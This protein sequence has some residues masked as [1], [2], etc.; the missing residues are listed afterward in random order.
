MKKY[1]PIFFISIMFTACFNSSSLE[2]D[3]EICVKENKF[4]YVTEVLDYRT[5]QMKP[6][7]ICK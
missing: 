2:D 1:L 3:K 6:K 5:G 7:V 4:F